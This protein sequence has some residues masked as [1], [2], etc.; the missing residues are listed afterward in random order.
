M[1]HPRQSANETSVPRSEL[2]NKTPEELIAIASKEIVK[3]LDKAGTL[4]P[5]PSLAVQEVVA[6]F[7]NTYLDARVGKQEAVAALGQLRATLNPNVVTAIESIIQR[8]LKK[9]PNNPDQ[10]RHPNASS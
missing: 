1:E 7:V 4:P 6:Q 2:S 10:K 8:E 9:T 3:Q 5:N